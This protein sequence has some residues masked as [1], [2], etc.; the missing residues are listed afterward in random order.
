MV[1]DG[2][3]IFVR[4]GIDIVVVECEFREEDQLLSNK[5]RRCGL[6]I[7]ISQVRL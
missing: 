6:T 4:A 7:F 3:A 2:S 1:Y 5:Y